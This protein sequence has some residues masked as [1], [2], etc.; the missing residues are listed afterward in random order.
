MR[1]PRRFCPP[2]RACG[3]CAL[4]TPVVCVQY[5][6]IDYDLPPFRLTALLLASGVSWHRY[7]SSENFGGSSVLSSALFAP[8]IVIYPGS[9]SIFLCFIVC[10]LL[11]PLLGATAD[12]AAAGWREGGILSDTLAAVPLFL[13]FAS[14]STSPP[15][16]PARGPQDS[17]SVFVG[18]LC[19]SFT[20]CVHS[21][22]CEY[23]GSN[24]ERLHETLSSPKKIVVR[25]LGN[26]SG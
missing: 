1:R 9:F 7:P 5:T 19:S 3:A 10:C 8:P 22:A 14:L 11:L 26:D 12:G 21:S 23:I 4:R 16:L 25:F 15:L 20:L 6:A 17:T 24:I 2:S 18:L 13:P